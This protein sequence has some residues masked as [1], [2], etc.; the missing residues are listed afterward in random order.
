MEI[1][2]GYSIDLQGGSMK[3]SRNGRITDSATV[4]KVLATLADLAD[5]VEGRR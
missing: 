5:R 1:S 2:G 3:F 4:E